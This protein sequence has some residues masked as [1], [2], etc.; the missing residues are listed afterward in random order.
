MDIADYQNFKNFLANH[1]KITSIR[2]EDQFCEQLFS[3]LREF[4]IIFV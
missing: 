4:D 3:T 2:L 1:I